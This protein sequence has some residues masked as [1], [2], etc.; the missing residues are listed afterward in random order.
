MK[1]AGHFVVFVIVFVITSVFFI[2]GFRTE[3]NSMEPQTL[4]VAEPMLNLS[5]DKDV[6]YSSEEMKLNASIKFEE[7]INVTLRLYGVPDSRGNYRISE[8]RNISAGPERTDEAFLFL[9]PSCYGCA[10]VSPGDYEI[11]MELIRDG[12]IIGNC[13]KTVKLEK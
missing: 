4:T 8:E 13:S 7:E 3:K 5:S 6:Y 11:V 10:G 2:S 1:W 12:E 9:M